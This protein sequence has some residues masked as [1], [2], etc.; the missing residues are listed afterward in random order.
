LQRDYYRVLQGVFGKCDVTG[1]AN[2]GSEYSRTLD[3]Q[4]LFERIFRQ[5]RGRRRV[6]NR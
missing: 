1:E 5:R 6:S 4:H 3:S 2:E